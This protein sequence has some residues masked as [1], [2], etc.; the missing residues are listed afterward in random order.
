MVTLLVNNP[1]MPL[2]DLS[3]LRLLSCGGSPQ[4]PAVVA[5]ALAC[6]GC[7]FFVSYGMTECCGK[8]SMSLMPQSEEW[9]AQ[10]QPEEVMERV[11]SSGRPF[12]IMEVRAK[13]EALPCLV[14]WHRYWSQG[15]T[16]ASACQH[17]FYF[18]QSS[19]AD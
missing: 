7:E 2:L 1:L 4:T 5:K 9:W 6:F 10:V 3:C 11:N 8:I 13:A 18:S 19:Y 12:L 17:T 14:T 15:H 16:I